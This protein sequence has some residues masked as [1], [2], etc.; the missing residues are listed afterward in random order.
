MLPLLPEHHQ[1]GRGE[2]PEHPCEHDEHMTGRTCT[3][4]HVP[5]QHVCTPRAPRSTNRR[6]GEVLTIITMGMQ[7]MRGV[8]ALVLCIVHAL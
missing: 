3:R 7:C 4:A 2:C 6:P 8:L 1:A 5:A